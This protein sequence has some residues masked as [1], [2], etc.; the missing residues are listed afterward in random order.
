MRKI[1]LD[2]NILLT[3][4]RI[5]V[6]SEI[7]RICDFNYKICILDKTLD[8]LS[9]KRGGAL[10]IDILKAKDVLIIK[11]ENKKSVD[12]NIFELAKND[13]DIIVATQDM[14]LKRRLK[15]NDIKIITVRQ[16][17]YLKFVN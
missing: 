10:A 3:K 1:L 5:D 13:K 15:K 8:E 11:T 4:Y 7:S 17:R 12:D 14:E 9:N 6:F 2:T 16:N